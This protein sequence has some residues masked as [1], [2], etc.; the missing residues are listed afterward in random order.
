[1]SLAQNIEMRTNQE[2]DELDLV[3]R[4][5][6]G[7]DASRF[8]P[9]YTQAMVLTESPGCLTSDKGI[10]CPAVNAN[11]GKQL[12]FGELS[13]LQS[14]INGTTFLSAQDAATEQANP[15]PRWVVAGFETPEFNAD[16]L[17]VKLPNLTCQSYNFCKSA[18]SQILYH[19]PRFTNAGKTYGELFYEVPE[20]TYVS[21]GN[22]EELNIN[23]LDVALVNKN[24]RV[25]KDLTGSTTIVIHIRHR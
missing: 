12:G 23:E 13:Y 9:A 5:W 11:M 2:L 22:T 4:L 14:G 16:T 7:V 15:A 20:K 1:M 24:E 8:S 3:T 21:L 18:P 19:L 10:Y 25:V 17:F 6:V